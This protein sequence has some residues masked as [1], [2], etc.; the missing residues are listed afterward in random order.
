MNTVES[1]II[2]VRKKIA[3]ACS[4]VSRNPSD[5]VL[6]PASKTRNPD[7]IR[8]AISAG[9]E[10][11]GENYVQEFLEKYEEMTNECVWHMIGHLQRNKVKRIIGKV[12][13]IQSVDSVELANTIEKEAA[14]A[15]VTADVLLE[16]NIAGEESKWGFCPDETMDVAK[17]IG[18]LPHVHVKGLMTSA[19]Y[20]ENPES[21]RTYFRTMKK[22]FDNLGSLG[23]NSVSAEVLSMGMSGDYEVAVEEGST[24]VRI[25]TAIFGER[26]YPE[27]NRFRIENINACLRI[28]IISCHDL[29]NKEPNLWLRLT[30]TYFTDCIKVSEGQNER[31]A[32]SSYRTSGLQNGP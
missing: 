19:P 11:F 9:V 2:T 28:N 18:S 6:C 4:K 22:L 8:E 27:K 3:E 12:A 24:M 32:Y 5:V 31:H 14:K 15:G 13:L 21:N 23:S 25:G 20:T 10:V 29:Q 30:N 17:Y 7:E 16:I 1:N 26:E